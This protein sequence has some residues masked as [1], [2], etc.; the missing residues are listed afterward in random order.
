MTFTLQGG[1]LAYVWTDGIEKNTA[2][3]HRKK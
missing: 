3:L 1:D 2:T